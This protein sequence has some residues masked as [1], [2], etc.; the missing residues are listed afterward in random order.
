VF[1]PYPIVIMT[2][3]SLK[4][5]VILLDAENA[6][7]NVELISDLFPLL[8]V[9][10]DVYLVSHDPGR[11]A[12]QLKHVLNDVV[13]YLHTHLFYR[14]NLHPVHPFSSRASLEKLYQGFSQTTYPF[15]VEAYRHQSI[16]RLMVLPILQVDPETK[17]PELEH[18]LTFLRERTMVPSIYCSAG[19]SPSS[20]ASAMQT[21][22]ER[23]VLALESS[24][25]GNHV[26]YT[27]GCH[28]AF[29]DL[30]AWIGGPV[31]HG[32]PLC[33]CAVIDAGRGTV[34]PGVV[35]T[36]SESRS[37]ASLNGDRHEVLSVFFQLDED[38]ML[39]YYLQAIPRL[40]ETLTMNNREKEYADV[41][42]QLG[43][44]CIKR[45]WYGEA[46][47][48]FGVLLARP[49]GIDDAATLYV[50]KALCHLKKEE[51]SQAE[52]ALNQAEHLDPSV[53]LIYYYRGHCEFALRDY[54]EAIDLI[55][56]ALDMGAEHVPKGDAF[57]Y[58]GLSHI[59]IEEYDD[60]LRMMEN[61]E[62]FYTPHQLSPVLYYKGVCHFGNKDLSTAY[63]L[64]QE[65][66]NAHPNPEDLSSIYLYL[67]MCHKEQAEYHEALHMLEQALFAE[68]DRLETHNLMGYCY[69]KLKEHERAIES[70]L[71]AV[72]IDPTSGIDW[73]NLGVN[74]R[75]LGDD[76]KAILL[77]K[78][79]V[80][81][82]PTLGFA[83]KH[84]QELQENKKS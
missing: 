20:F 53:A 13:D 34:A 32:I 77:F 61:A 63:A 17:Q 57:F 28:F 4:N 15:N 54:I 6:G 38:Y 30:L 70:F 46:L 60:G 79:A 11:D 3:F 67:G 1:L 74:V 52:A 47:Q 33:R 23:I 16:T 39:R 48:L 14:I 49:S 50:Y 76:D 8:D 51:I 42:K 10:S 37:C 22:R 59:N 18:F 71:R 58:M 78:K 26:V 27:L 12:F 64:F 21:E 72:E 19:V 55:Q 9:V 43:M 62:P 84:L 81:L 73:A 40:Q 56:K 80:S 65:A 7:R 83:W 75:A 41:I 31:K 35:N 69:F 82:D 68:E 24:V 45:T 2:A 36:S 25:S 29:D 44:E 5:L 66:L